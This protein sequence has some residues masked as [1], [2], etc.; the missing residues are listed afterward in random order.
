M[1]D[2][3]AE[4]A[5]KPKAAKP[6]GGKP[7][8]G[9][10]DAAKAKAEKPKAE[11]AKKSKGEKAG[12]SLE[13]DEQPNS[14]PIPKT[15]LREHYAGTVRAKLSRQFGFSNPH[16]VPKL[17]KIVLN[18]GAG[19]AAKN[20]KVLDAVAAELGA[21]TG[22]KAQINKA[23]KAISNFS[24]REGL[25]IGASVTLRGTRM[26]EFLDRFINV[27]VPRF[28][29]FRGLPTRS[30]D[31][32]GNYTLGIKE[33]MVFPEIEYDKVETIHGMDITFVTSAGRDDVAMALL[34]EMGMP[35]RGETP[36]AVN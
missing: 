14:G 20:P 13:V 16:Q 18:V 2:T 29:D 7:E 10:P 15:R 4:K 9:K 1:A 27:T 3:K 8:G 19:A 26:Y 28:R 24:L 33:Q 35:F 31:G 36:V 30:F 22:Q 17:V 11:K 6:E 21:I 5:E 32:R 34:R 12:I 25:P 23:K